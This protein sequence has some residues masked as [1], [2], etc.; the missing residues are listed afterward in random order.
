MKKSH[1]HKVCCLYYFKWKLQII[2]TETV[3]VILVTTVWQTWGMN[4]ICHFVGIIYILSTLNNVKIIT[5]ITSWYH[6]LLNGEMIRWRWPMTN[7]KWWSFIWGCVQRI[8]WFINVYKQTSNTQAKHMHMH[9]HMSPK[10]L[11]LVS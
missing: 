2:K 8:S 9:M 4:T 7:F 10:M 11:A 6:V 5:I 3:F 1:N